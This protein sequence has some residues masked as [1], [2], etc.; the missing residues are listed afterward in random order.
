MVGIFILE[1]SNGATEINLWL[2]EYDTTVE[3]SAGY[4]RLSLTGSPARALAFRDTAEAM[5]FWTQV[6]K[7]VPVR[8]TDGKP[9]R[10]LTVFTVSVSPLPEAG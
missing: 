10:P 1:T 6:S 8:D 7:T 9:N 2:E 3:D 5:A 4:G